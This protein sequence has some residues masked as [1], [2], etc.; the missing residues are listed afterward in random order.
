MLRVCDAFSR[1]KRVEMD[2]KGIEMSL[3]CGINYNK[4]RI[5]TGNVQH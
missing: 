1:T 3:T 2:A 5:M 4:I